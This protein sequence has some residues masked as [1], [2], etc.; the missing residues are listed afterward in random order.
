MVEGTYTDIMY[1]VSC[2]DVFAIFG[3]MV[4]AL[5]VVIKP[6]CFPA[7]G[8]GIVLAKGATSHRNLIHSIN[9]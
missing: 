3:I 1:T 9:S 8:Y 5:R 4:H 2:T 6:R 7:E